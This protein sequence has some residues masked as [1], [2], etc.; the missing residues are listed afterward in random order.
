LGESCSTETEGERFSTEIE[1]LREDESLTSNI[2]TNERRVM[3]EEE[4]AD[5][6]L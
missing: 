5:R 6:K 2:A 1:G 3:G 4:L